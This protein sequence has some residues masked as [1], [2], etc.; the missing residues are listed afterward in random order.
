MVG[1]KNNMD[2]LVWILTVF[3]ITSFTVLESY[4]WGKFIFLG[5]SVFIY[6]LNYLKSKQVLFPIDAYQRHMIVLMCFTLISSLWA[7]SSSDAIEKG[8]TFFQ[9]FV[10]FS[11][12][13]MYYNKADN[14]DNLLSAIKW[15][16]YII[17]IYTIYFFGIEGLISSTL[18]TRLANSFSNVNSIGLICAL[19]CVIQVFQLTNKGPKYQIA[20]MALPILVISATQ[21]RKALLFL[22]IGVF[23]V[24]AFCNKKRNAVKTIIGIATAAIIVFIMISAVSSL[25]IFSGLN[26]RMQLMLSAVNGE[27]AVDHST[28]IRNEMVQ[29]GIEWWKRYP[30]GG[31]GIGSPHILAQQ[32]VGA[33]HYLHNN[34][35]EL[36]CGGGLVGFCIYYFNHFYLLFKLFRY[37]AVDYRNSMFSIIWILL[38]LFM[39]YGMVSYYSKDQWFYLMVIFLNVR[40]LR[41]KVYK[42]Q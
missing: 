14:I 15:A 9:I 30:I 27:G 22:L 23:A 10:S 29:L 12:V 7:I 2:R 25:E 26:N 28:Q 1:I 39:D 4:T 31:V 37:R 42:I 24:I 3:L 36:L 20:F 21:S 11:L 18:A 8:I 40:F 6:F 33:D 13:Y 16:G 35:V 19:S 5:I 34:F 32:F 41:K 17:S 38:M